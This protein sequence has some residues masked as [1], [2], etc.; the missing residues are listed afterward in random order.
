MPAELTGG[1]AQA[2]TLAMG[3]GCKYRLS[4][5]GWSAAHLLL[6]S[7]VPNRPPYQCMAQGV[8]KPALESMELF[9]IVKNISYL[10]HLRLDKLIPRI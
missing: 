3:N 9:F 10:S 1:G 6:C 8:G 7:Q 5:T 2:I 4:F